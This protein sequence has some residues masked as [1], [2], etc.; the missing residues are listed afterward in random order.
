LFGIKDVITVT[1]DYI[2]SEANQVVLAYQKKYHK[3]VAKVVLVGGGICSHSNSSCLQFYS[4]L[5]V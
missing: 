1:L 3:N 5:D 2:F 4:N